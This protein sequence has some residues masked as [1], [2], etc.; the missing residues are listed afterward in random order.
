[1]TT[2]A[3]C[4]WGIFTVVNFGWFMNRMTTDTAIVVNKRSVRL[5]VALDA[6]RDITMAAVVTLRTVDF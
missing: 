1:M 2:G 4:C 6:V 3:E 5:F